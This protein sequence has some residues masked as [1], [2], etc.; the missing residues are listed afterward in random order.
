MNKHSLGGQGEGRNLVAEEQF[1]RDIH[2]V[3]VGIVENHL[4]APY[5]LPRRL[6]GD[7]YL[8]F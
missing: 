5:V 3:W 7:G 6:N 8:K 1:L 4:V 2:N